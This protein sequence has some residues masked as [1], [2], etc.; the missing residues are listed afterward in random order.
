M[1]DQPSWLI[2]QSTICLG[3]ASFATMSGIISI[4]IDES[5]LFLQ[6]IAKERAKQKIETTLFRF[7]LQKS[8]KSHISIKIY[9][10]LRK[11]YGQEQKISVMSQKWIHIFGP[12]NLF[13]KFGGRILYNKR[14][15]IFR[16][17]TVY[18]QSELY[19]NRYP[20]DMTTNYK[21]KM[22]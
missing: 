5:C 12:Q 14:P 6:S 13:S 16:F 11:V 17:E 3:N 4:K 7:E 15:Y 19:I 8:L 2:I 21:F 1:P 10:H 18:F 22:L 9:G 20:Y